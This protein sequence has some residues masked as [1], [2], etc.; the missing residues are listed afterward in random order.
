[1]ITIEQRQPPDCPDDYNRCTKASCPFNML[2]MVECPGLARLKVAISEC[3]IF[4]PTFLKEYP[5]CDPCSWVEDGNV[6]G[7]PILVPDEICEA[8]KCDL[9]SKYTFPFSILERI[10]QLIKQ[11]SIMFY[12]RRKPY[13]KYFFWNIREHFLGTFYF[14]FNSIDREYS[15]LKPNDPHNRCGINK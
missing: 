11:P 4:I 13:F 12:V 5:E 3:P 10:C 1:M 6:Q 14:V 2:K 15:H 9:A 8:F 7:K